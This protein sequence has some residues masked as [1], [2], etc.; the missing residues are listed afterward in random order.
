MTSMDEEPRSSAGCRYLRAYF[1]YWSL[2]SGAG[3]ENYSC[4]FFFFLSLLS[5]VDFHLLCESVK[6]G[7]PKNR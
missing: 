5:I 1:P 6:K 2:R 7:N 4:L 3:S